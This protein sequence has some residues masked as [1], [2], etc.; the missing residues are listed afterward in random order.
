MNTNCVQGSDVNP[1]DRK[2]ER[3][4]RSYPGSEDLTKR[5]IRIAP[6]TCQFLKTAESMTFFFQDSK[7]QSDVIRYNDS[8]LSMQ[9]V[10]LLHFYTQL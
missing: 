3:R 6:T 5:F 4:P 1:E 9:Q 7:S 10:L 8:F 2:E